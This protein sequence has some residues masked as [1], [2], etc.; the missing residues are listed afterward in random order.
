VRIAGRGSDAQQFRASGLNPVIAAIVH[1]KSTYLADAVDH[2]RSE[3][4]G[5]PVELL[6]HTSPSRESEAEPQLGV[7]IAASVRAER[8][9]PAVTG[10]STK[11]GGSET[12]VGD[13]TPVVSSTG[14]RFGANLISA[15]GAQGQLRFMLTK[16]RVT[17]AVFMDFLKR[18]LV[19]GRTLSRRRG[20]PLAG[21]GIP[22]T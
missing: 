9:A 2:L 1:W 20:H 21:A 18:L 6:A 13:G 14:A 4:H 5:G 17:A 10:V 22:P 8:T 3:R 7:S 15:V 11:P 16:G 12:P 19:N